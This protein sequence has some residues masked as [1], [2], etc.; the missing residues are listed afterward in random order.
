MPYDVSLS[1]SFSLSTIYLVSHN[2]LSAYDK[3]S[4]QLLWSK[5]LADEIRT[6]TIHQGVLI[7][8]LANQQI[9]GLN[10]EGQQLWQQHL[11][12]ES[13]TGDRFIPCI[14]KNSDD[15]RLDRS[16]IVIPSK[17]GI[18]ILDPVRG[19]TLSS[20]TLKQDLNALSVYDSFTNCFYAVVDNAVLCIELKIVN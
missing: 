5:L 16:I 6:T 20:L 2:R 13:I 3:K 1:P 15:P 14:I 18:S 10:D 9:L 17:R 12:T 19:E 7:V 11:P 8:Y 4:R